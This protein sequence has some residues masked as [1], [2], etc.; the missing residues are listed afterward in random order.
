ML[1]KILRR[2]A[3]VSLRQQ[4]LEL[5][6][7]LDAEERRS[8]VLQTEIDSLAAVVARDRERIKSEGAAYARA[9]AESEGITIN[10]RS[11]E[12]IL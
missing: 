8:T 9:R 6:S 1:K 5:E 11:R 7:K 12:S 10:E 2:W 4:I 3:D